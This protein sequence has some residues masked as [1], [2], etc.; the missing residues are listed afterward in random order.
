MARAV[1]GPERKRRRA[2]DA[3]DGDVGATEVRL[4]QRLV[5]GD[6]RDTSLRQRVD[7][8][9]LRAG[10]V[11]HRLDELEVHGPDVGDH[12]DIGSREPGEPGDLPEAAHPHLGDQELGLRLQPG[13]RQRDADLVVVV[14]LVRDRPAMGRAECEEDVLR[15]GLAGRAGDRHDPRRRTLAHRAGDRGKRGASSP[16][17]RAS[18]PR[19]VPAR[20]RRSRP[21]RRSRR[22]DRPPRSVSNRPAAR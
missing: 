16:A 6:D 22:T 11:L 3:V 14:A 20:A 15:R 10:D 1:R 19:R 7:Q 9:G 17:G 13:Q 8:L 2:V 21:R 18:P 5:R 4:E 12:P